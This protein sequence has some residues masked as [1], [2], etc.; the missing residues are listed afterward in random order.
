[1]SSITIVE[2]PSGL[3]VKPSGE[4]WWAGFAAK[5]YTSVDRFQCE[6]VNCPIYSALI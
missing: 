4:G 1:M 5:A 6:V 2:V 3:S